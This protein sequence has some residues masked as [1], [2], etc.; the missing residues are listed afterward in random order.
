[1]RI[2]VLLFVFFSG[3]LLGQNASLH[4]VTQCASTICLDGMSD[5][6]IVLYNAKGEP[7]LRD[8]HINNGYYY[9]D[10]SAYPPGIYFVTVRSGDDERT[11]KVIIR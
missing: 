7:C 5:C 3:V 10:A 1:M 6:D 11:A 4:E 9:I 2:I 8:V